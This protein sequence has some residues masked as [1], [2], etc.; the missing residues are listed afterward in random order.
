MTLHCTEISIV[1]L[2]GFRQIQIH[3]FLLGYSCTAHQIVVSFDIDDPVQLFDS[4]YPHISHSFRDRIS[5]SL[6]FRFS[7]KDTINDFVMQH[8]LT[9]QTSFDN[10]TYICPSIKWLR[11]LYVYRHTYKNNNIL[12]RENSFFYYSFYY[13]FYVCIKC[14]NFFLESI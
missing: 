12:Y 1:V 13:L 7:A 10:C 4:F 8:I 3:T 9:S 2:K 5:K 11:N 6:S 14:I